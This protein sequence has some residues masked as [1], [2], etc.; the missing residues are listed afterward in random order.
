MKIK[1]LKYSLCIPF[2]GALLNFIVLF[3]EHKRIKHFNIFMFVLYML[4]SALLLLLGII[5]I[6][7][8]YRGINFSGSFQKFSIYFQIFGIVFGGWLMGIPILCYWKTH[9]Y[10]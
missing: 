5:I 4:I 6:G 1:F 10:T 2:Y 8:I 3:L 9:K 7:L